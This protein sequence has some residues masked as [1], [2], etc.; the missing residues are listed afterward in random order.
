MEAGGKEDEQPNHGQPRVA[1]IVA[2]PSRWR[3]Q[4]GIVAVEALAHGKAVVAAD[5]GRVPQVIRHGETGLL[6]RPDN[7]Q[8][9]EEELA[10]LLENPDLRRS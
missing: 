6:A 2:L 4:I 3:E 1:D 5:T 8:D 7:P 10:S 9:F